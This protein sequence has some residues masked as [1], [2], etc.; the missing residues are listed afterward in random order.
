MSTV[1]YV[2]IVTHTGESTVDSND[3]L[4]GVCYRLFGYC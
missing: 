3:L 4:N 2:T 1:D